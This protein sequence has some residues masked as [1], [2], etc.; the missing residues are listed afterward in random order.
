MN[1]ESCPDCSG[2]SSPLHNRR[3]FL[4]SSAGAAAA[5]TGGS[6]IPAI[7][8]E[9]KKASSETLVKTFYDSL[10]DEQ[11]KIICFP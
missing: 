7:G 11:R 8:A 5:I 3:S 2:G 9:K 4:R 10:N 6:I 1:P